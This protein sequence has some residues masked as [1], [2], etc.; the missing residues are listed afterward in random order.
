MSI[1]IKTARPI[2]ILKEHSI[3]TERILAK[4][5]LKFNKLDTYNILLNLLSDHEIQS[6]KINNFEI[7]FC[8]C[9]FYNIYVYKNKFY[10]ELNQDGFEFKN[11][12]TNLNTLINENFIKN[13]DYLNEINI[14]FLKN[15]YLLLEKRYLALS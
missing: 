9:N 1:N 7:L 6:N 12:I 3:K 14:N 8:L 5:K 4:V 10:F 13:I 11:I 15:I 2:D